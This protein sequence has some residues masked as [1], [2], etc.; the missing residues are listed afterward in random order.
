MPSKKA[1]A[2]K[3]LSFGGVIIDDPRYRSALRF[4]LSDGIFANVMLALTETFGIAAAVYLKAPAIAIALLGSLPLLLSSI[5]QLL[6]PLLYPTTT[7][8]KRYVLRGTTLQSLFLFCVASSGFLPE[9]I[10][11]WA[12]VLF[13][14]LYGFFGNV[15]AGFWI[16]WM[17]D[18]IPPAVRGRH[19]AWR[20]RIFSITQLVCA[21]TA[22][23]ISRRYTT[24]NAPWFLF[25]TVFIA[26]GLS[27]LLSTKML[28]L[29]FEPHTAAVSTRYQFQ[30]VFRQ[31]RPF[32]FYCIS[33]ALLQGAVAITGPFFNVWYIRDLQFNYFTLSAVSVAT[34]LGTIAAL[35][36]W[37]RIADSFGNRTVILFTVFLIATIPLPYLAA[38]RAWQ[39]FGL[40]FYTGCC[41]S[42]Y[43][44]SNF[45]YLLSA[46]GRKK[47]EHNISFAVAATGISVFLFSIL[48][49]ILATRLPQFFHFRLQSLFLLSALLR[50]T[51]FALFFV[52]YPHFEPIER[53]T[54]DLFHQ[55][56]GY[57]VGL[58]ILRNTFRA[59]RIK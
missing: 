55:I 9:S 37:G 57:R 59:F 5:G 50:F 32:L 58:G 48:G 51:V 38:D 23:L 4:S 45:N 42:G 28:S 39:I 26:A 17:G 8:R 22:G 14:A 54:I 52:R 47:T 11:P 46:A 35:P 41:W 16:A 49:G 56:P 40:N 31:Q 21:L 27:R 12:Y 44:L 13:F 20:N 6:I 25:A 24:T 43:N 30:S 53:G 29:Q 33:A 10:R 3:T 7:E 34:I 2:A 36:F 19:F 1:A 18:L 15:V